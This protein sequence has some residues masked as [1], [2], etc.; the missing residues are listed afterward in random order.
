MLCA[1]IS[2]KSTIIHPVDDVHLGRQIK[3]L[4]FVSK[5]LCAPQDLGQRP[6]NQIGHGVEGIALPS[7]A[8]KSIAS[9]APPNSPPS[10]PF[11]PACRGPTATRAV[12]ISSSQRH[13][14]SS[15]PFFCHETCCCSFCHETY[16]SFCYER[17]HF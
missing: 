8:C 12:A 5:G 1:K 2:I 16:Y 3:V 9:G 6:R 17:A 14:K 7:N 10:P 15:A 4:A 11:G 13:S